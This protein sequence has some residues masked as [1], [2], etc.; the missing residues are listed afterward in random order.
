MILQFNLNIYNETTIGILFY[1][2]YNNIGA[3]FVF[4]KRTDIQPKK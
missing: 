4:K 1:K 3:W 2:S